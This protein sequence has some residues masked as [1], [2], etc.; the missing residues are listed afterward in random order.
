MLRVMWTQCSS[1]VSYERCS[2]RA[3]EVNEMTERIPTSGS[4]GNSAAV[5][6]SLA[7]G[8][9]PAANNG[10]ESNKRTNCVARESDTTHSENSLFGT[11]SYFRAQTIAVDA[12]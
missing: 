10:W 4:A 12:N 11:Q 8:H 6:K 2:L 9:S 7:P 1:I 3:N 5:C